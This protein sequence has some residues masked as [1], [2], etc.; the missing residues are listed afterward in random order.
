M[1]RPFP[2]DEGQQKSPADEWL[3]GI[4]PMSRYPEEEPS[5]DWTWLWHVLCSCSRSEAG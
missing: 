4:L 5:W 2:E 1:I 3:N